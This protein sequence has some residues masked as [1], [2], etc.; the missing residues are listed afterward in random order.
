M[1]SKAHVTQPLLHNTHVFQPFQKFAARLVTKCWD[2]CY[3][4]LLSKQGLSLLSTRCRQQKVS[5]SAE[6]SFGGVM[7]P[8]YSLYFPPPSQPSS[9]SLHSPSSS[10]PHYCLM[11]PP[12]SK[13][14][15]YLELPSCLCCISSYFLSLYK[16]LLKSLSHM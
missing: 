15:L 16:C 12:F 10:Y 1:L 2:D 14:T 11:Y 5:I 6:G 13:C 7:H 8:T 4:S 9:P 3:A